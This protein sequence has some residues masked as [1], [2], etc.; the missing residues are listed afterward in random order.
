ML[1]VACNEQV[2]NEMKEMVWNS[3]GW[4]AGRAGSMWLLKILPLGDDSTVTAYTPYY[5]IL[6]PT[7]SLQH[8]NA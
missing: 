7:V 5:D 2:R 3:G 4:V 6:H 8:K 1:G